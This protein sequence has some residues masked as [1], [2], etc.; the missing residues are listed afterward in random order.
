MKFLITILLAVNI[1][2]LIFVA[3]IQAKRS[4]LEISSIESDIRVL[5]DKGFVQECLAF[6]Q[7]K[8]DPSIEQ[9]LVNF[10]D[11]NKKSL[12]RYSAM[13]RNVTGA[14]IC[15]TTVN[16]ILVGF[17]GF[18]LFKLKKRLNIEI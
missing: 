17:L 8:W 1:G 13:L 11:Q 6:L 9:A 10:S 16:T 4:N 3:F 15:I 18:K 2:C 14:L 7:Q 5:R 12:S